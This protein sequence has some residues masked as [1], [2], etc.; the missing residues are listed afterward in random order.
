MCQRGEEA[1]LS[2][3]GLFQLAFGL[4]QLAYIPK[5]S[6]GPPASPVLVKKG[7]RIAANLFRPEIEFHIEDFNAAGG[8]DVQRELFSGDLT[9]FAPDAVL[10]RQ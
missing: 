2:S 3:V 6:N 1:V 4:L 8:G 5:R 9:A 10:C 7:R